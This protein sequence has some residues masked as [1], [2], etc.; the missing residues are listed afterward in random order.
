MLP[1]LQQNKEDA[2]IEDSFFKMQEMENFLDQEDAKAM[3]NIDG[4]PSSSE[5]EEDDE[6]TPGM[7][8][9]FDDNDEVSL[10]IFY[11]HLFI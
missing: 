4:E 6:L 3:K 1:H 9:D 5:S 7:F 11:T 2:Q 8:D 10:R